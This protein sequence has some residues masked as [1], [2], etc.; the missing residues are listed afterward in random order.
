MIVQPCGKCPECGRV[1]VHQDDALHRFNV[2]QPC[3]RKVREVEKC[4]KYSEFNRGV[5]NDT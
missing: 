4:V 5:D 1:C 3:G 2:V